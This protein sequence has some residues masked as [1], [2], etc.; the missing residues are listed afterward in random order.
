[1]NGKILKENKVKNKKG[2]VYLYVSLWKDGKRKDFLIS[3]LVALA[4]I[5]NNFPE[6][7]H[8]DGNTLN[9]HVSNLRWFTHGENNR[10]KDGYGNTGI[11]GLCYREP[12]GRLPIRAQYMNKEGKKVGKCFT[13]DPEPR[14][15][16]RKEGRDITV[17]R[18][19]RLQK[20][21]V[22]NG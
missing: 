2:V 5:P 9:N 7:D 14:Y 13:I 8:I 15:K 1:V 12:E 19:E 3:R 18:H 10:N 21:R 20:K 6:V 11:L 4:F 22:K 17:I 16:N